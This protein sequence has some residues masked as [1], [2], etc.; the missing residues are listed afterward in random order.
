MLRGVVIRVFKPGDPQ[1]G[2]RRSPL[3]VLAPAI[4]CDVLIYDPDY[5][6]IL[7]DVAILR[8]S[9]GAV[10]S[11]VWVPRAASIDL[12]GQP[13]AVAGNGPLDPTV[14]APT[15]P[16]NM[17]GDHVVVGF[18]NNDLAQPII[19][20]QLDHPQNANHVPYGVPPDTK[21]AVTM[22]GWLWAMKADGTMIVDSNLASAGIIPPALPPVETPDPGAGN[23]E[24]SLPAG[25]KISIGL[26]L[27]PSPTQEPVVTK[28]FL[29]ALKTKL[30]AEQAAW[31]AAQAAHTAAA[32]AFT[33]LGEPAASTAAGAAATAASLAAS[34]CATLIASITT[35][36]GAGDPFLS[37]LLETD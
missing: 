6:T 36:E 17:D 12:T 15:N 20:G 23:L 1:L 13:F 18:M 4:L 25:R 32:T 8:R 28:S 27:A 24:I 10:D 34:A 11:E 14:L 9:A 19:L 5:V 30:Q 3:K 22:R 2:T 21:L 16:S 31:T 37:T 7:H 35:S 26:L 33:A 29:V